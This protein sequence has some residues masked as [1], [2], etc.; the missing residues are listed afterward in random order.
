ME[1]TQLII[2]KQLPEIEENL[3][4]V[5]NEIQQKVE[6][7]KQ[8]VCNE[9]TRQVIKKIRA[10]L[11]KELAEFEAQR[12]NVKEK[13]LVPYNNFEKV[14]KE[15]IS[16]KYSEA[17]R[18]LKKKIEEVENN[19]KK[20]KE[21]DLKA[22]FEEY[23][24]YKNITFIDFE[25]ANIKVGLA[26]SKTGLHKQAKDFID[27]IYSDINLIDTQEH[28]E[29][30]MIEYKQSLNVSNAITTVKNRYEEIEKEKKRQLEEEQKKAEIRL[31]Q[32]EENTKIALE[33]LRQQNEILDIPK[34][35]EKEE[36][37][38]L[39]FTVRATK[40]KLKALKQYLIDG[41]YD[42]E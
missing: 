39:K 38:T 8:L 13:I 3:K 4:L 14:Y 1:D 16:D 6:Q 10:D 20:E 37:L 18:E 28:R 35:E 19:L 30:I 29:E 25:R 34:V 15:C 5:S 24:K 7:A 21:A 17:D 22:Y 26:D 40:S 9:E 33:N 42:Y 31:K 11:N 2:V 12:K 23:K 27:K 32:Q 41:G 36:I